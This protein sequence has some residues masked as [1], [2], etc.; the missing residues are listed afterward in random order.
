[1]WTA[2]LNIIWLIIIWCLSTSCTD[3]VCNTVLRQGFILTEWYITLCLQERRKIAE[4]SQVYWEDH[5][6]MLGCWCSMSLVKLP[7]GFWLSAISSF[8]LG[9]RDSLNEVSLYFRNF[10]E[11]K[12]QSHVFRFSNLIAQGNLGALLSWTQT[13]KERDRGKEQWKHFFLVLYVL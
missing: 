4:D 12:R 1:M 11:K 10:Y 9:K 6:C 3:T 7:K 5:R 13:G 2:L 8:A